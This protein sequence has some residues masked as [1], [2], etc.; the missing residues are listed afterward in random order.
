MNIELDHAVIGV[1]DLDVATWTYRR[2]G[3]DVRSGGRHVGRG[4]HNALIRFG[5]DYIELMSVFDPAEAA[6]DPFA[7][8]LLRYLEHHVGGLIGYVFSTD[9]VAALH[10]RMTAAELRSVGP[11]AMSRK[12]AD[13]G[14]LSWRML[15]P[16]EIS[17]RRPLPTV[18]QWDQG[19]AERE[20]VDGQS[21]HPNGAEHI[22]RVSIAARDLEATTASFARAYGLRVGAATS[23]PEL[24]ARARSIELP[25]VELQILAPVGKGL[26]QDAL[27]RDG[28]G[29]FEVVLRGLADHAWDTRETVGAVLR[30]ES[31]VRT[32]AAGAA[33]GSRA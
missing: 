17:W 14:L 27:D 30:I 24:A 23:V 18:I 2:L 1:R 16:G 12:R 25:N 29:P 21:R 15:I 19:P 4:T 32:T 26:V 31:G 10:Q 33:V 6:T 9:D 5:P 11:F 22:R 8:S 13:G 7:S 3:F 20:G 28:E